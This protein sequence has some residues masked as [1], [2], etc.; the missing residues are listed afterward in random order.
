MASRRTSMTKRILIIED[1]QDSRILI[2]DLLQSLAYTVLVAEDGVQGL[3]MAQAEMPDLI[4]MDLSLP[5]M[6]GWA[7]AR[8]LKQDTELA[9]IPI[10]A[11]TAH[12]MV[13]DRE[14]ALRVGCDDYVSKPIDMRELTSKLKHYLR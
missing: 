10:I 8:Q 9:H 1:N 14:E 5:K 7:L 11:L 6:D 13:G 3:T 12:A 4:L 2:T